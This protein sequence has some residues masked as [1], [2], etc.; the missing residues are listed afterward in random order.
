MLSCEL[1][2]CKRKAIILDYV[3]VSHATDAEISNMLR[4]VEPGS[5][6]W[7]YN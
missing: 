4:E 5:N 3:H 2:G 6:W 7:L 1:E